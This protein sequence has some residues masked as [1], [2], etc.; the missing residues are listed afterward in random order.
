MGVAIGRFDIAGGILAPM[1]GYTD[2]AFRE[3]CKDCGAALTVTEMVSVRALIHDNAATMRLMQLSEKE[4][5]SCVQ[6]FGSDPDDF[7][8]VAENIC[9]DIIDV[10]MGCPM[11]KIVK[12]G[13]G[14]ALIKTPDRAGEIVAAIK[15]VTDKPVTVK[16]RLGYKTGEQCAEQLIK[17]V[18]NAGAAA[19]Y[20][21]GRYAEQRYAGESDITLVRE[22]G[23]RAPIPV[24]ANGDV[25]S[26]AAEGDGAVMIGRAALKNPTLFGGGTIVDTFDLAR[27][28][29][30][31]LTKYF[32][33]RYSV[34]QCRK[35]FV[36]FFSG[37][38]GGR[39]MRIKINNADTIGDILAAIDEC[40]QNNKQ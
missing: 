9:C 6:L 40:E 38:V 20:L 35:L 17:S 30:A 23:K 32:D 29:I 36:H 21:H 39:A 33:N 2:I 19:V 26:I 25:T 12:N 37:T 22:I 13:D 1:A 15:A 28:Y 24:I 16:T 31:L 10:N 27:R 8:R 4:R 18:A 14:A 11:P 34:L 5:P 7:K 3:L